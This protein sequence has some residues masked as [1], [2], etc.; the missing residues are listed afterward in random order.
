MSK[1]D[2]R[3]TVPEPTRVGAARAMERMI[4]LATQ[5]LGRAASN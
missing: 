1:A 2:R 4:A 5:G 3:I